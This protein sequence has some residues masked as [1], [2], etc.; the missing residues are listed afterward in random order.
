MLHSTTEFQTI[1]CLPE[2]I[3]PLEVQNEFAVSLHRIPPSVDSLG[4]AIPC[5]N[6]CNFENITFRSV[7]MPLYVMTVS[8][9]FLHPTGIRC[10]GAAGAVLCGTWRPA[11]SLKLTFQY[12]LS[13]KSSAFSLLKEDKSCTLPFLHPP[14]YAKKATFCMF[15]AATHNYDET[16]PSFYCWDN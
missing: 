13:S 9:S 1:Q 7:I 8:R 11:G 12:K 4:S 15:F 6:C 2:I 14:L 3:C 16:L 10:E 5:Y